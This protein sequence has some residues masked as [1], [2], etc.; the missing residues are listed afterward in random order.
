MELLG[1]APQESDVIDWADLYQKCLDAGHL[2]RMTE[3][4]DGGKEL[5]C[6]TQSDSEE[7]GSD[8]STANQV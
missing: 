4:G 1:L 7:T 2:P 6:V 5:I 8:A 3:S